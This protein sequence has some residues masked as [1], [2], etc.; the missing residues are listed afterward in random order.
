[1]STF[2]KTIHTEARGVMLSTLWIFVA[3]NIIVADIVGF[4]NP[5]ALETMR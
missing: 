5:G 4:L 1:M 2:E 3:C